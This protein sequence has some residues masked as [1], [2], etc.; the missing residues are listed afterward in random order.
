MSFSPETTV[1]KK[2]ASFFAI[3]LPVF[4]LRTTMMQMRRAL[5]AY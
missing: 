2:P 1:Q 3:Q 5:L 4:H